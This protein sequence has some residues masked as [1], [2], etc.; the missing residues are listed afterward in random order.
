MVVDAANNPRPRT[1][2]S[3]LTTFLWID[4]RDLTVVGN[5][6]KLFCVTIK[7]EHLLLFGAFPNDSTRLLSQLATVANCKGLIPNPVSLSA[8]Y[9]EWDGPKCDRARMRGSVGT[10]MVVP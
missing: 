10:I 6:T 3:S 9:A 1:Q 2:E 7:S 4:C 5:N 8:G